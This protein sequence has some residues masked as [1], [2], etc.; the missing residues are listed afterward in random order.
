MVRDLWERAKR[1]HSTPREIG[2]SVGLGAFVACSPFIGFHL[3]IAALLATVFRLNRLWAMV[4]SRLSTTPIFLATTFAEINAAH[5]LRTH[6]W[7]SITLHTALHQ[8]PELLVDWAIGSVIV[9]SAVAVA[10]GLTARTLAS[11]WQQ[12]SSRELAPLRRRS[13]ESPQ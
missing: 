13:S 5:Y 6:S 1:E 7:A 8:A 12:V 10:V 11:R 3:G 4:G 2:L 9:G